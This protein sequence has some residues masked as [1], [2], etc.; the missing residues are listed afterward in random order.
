M[1]VSVN[2]IGEYN[3]GIALITRNLKNKKTG[4]NQLAAYS[5]EEQIGSDEPF[6]RWMTITSRI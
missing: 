4:H 3:L 2:C 5:V 1:K 6:I